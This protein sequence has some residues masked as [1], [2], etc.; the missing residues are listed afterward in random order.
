VR[1][2]LEKNYAV[3]EGRRTIKLA[4]QALTETVEA[5]SK[6]IE[7]AV[8]EPLSGLRFLKDEEVDE[9]VKEIVDEKAAADA[10]RKK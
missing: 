3:T 6:S 7:I 4:I 8:V 1:E 5:G 2:Y 10:A 9:L